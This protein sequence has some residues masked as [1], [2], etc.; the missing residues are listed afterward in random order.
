MI[1]DQYKRSTNI[2]GYWGWVAQKHFGELK[3]LGQEKSLHGQ[4][5]FGATLD[6]IVSFT[7]FKIY[8]KAAL[9]N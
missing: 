6:L 3:K 5:W 4:L 9:N 8:P 2:V 7:F 1:T